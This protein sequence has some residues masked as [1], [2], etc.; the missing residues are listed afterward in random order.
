MKTLAAVRSLPAR[1]RLMA[2]RL[3]DALPEGVI[4]IDASDRVV[5][6]NAP[7]LALFPALRPDLLLARG[8]RAPDVLDAVMRARASGRPERATWLDRVPVERFFEL[9]VAPM[10]GPPGSATMILTLRDL[11]EARRVER[12]R[13]DFVANASHE[14]R[15]PL[16]SLLGFVETL[17][18]PA[19]HDEQAR[20]KFLGIMREQARRMTRLVDDLLSLSRIEQN[21]HLLPQSPVDLVTIL[22]HIADTLAPMALENNTVLHVDA[23]ASVIVPGDRDELLRVVENLVE[24]AIKYGASDPGCEDRDVEIT[25]LSQERHCVFSVRDHGP[26][27]APE[28]LPRLTERFYRVDAGQSRAKGGTGLGLAIVKHIV[29]RHRGRLGIESLPEQGSTFSVTLPLYAS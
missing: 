10:E 29:A 24:N 25:L 13:V 1:D 17:Q 26:G 11:S 5:A 16:A 2:A 18:G 9:N 27:I 15:T 7:A 6:V 14:L 23:P 12:M 28:H 8:L 4:V 21:L 20:V 3:I 22:R 19:R